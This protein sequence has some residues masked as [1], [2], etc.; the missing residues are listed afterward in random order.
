MTGGVTE[1]FGKIY[2]V[3]TDAGWYKLLVIGVFNQKL[4]LC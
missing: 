1:P 2:R 4:G 3:Q